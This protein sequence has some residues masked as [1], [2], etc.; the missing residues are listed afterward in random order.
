MVCSI[1]LLL[2][3]LDMLDG[4]YVLYMLDLVDL[5]DLVDLLDLE[6]DSSKKCVPDWLSEYETEFDL[7]RLAP[8]KTIVWL[9]LCILVEFILK[10]LSYFIIILENTLRHNLGRNENVGSCILFDF[11]INSI[12]CSISNLDFFIRF[13]RFLKFS[14]SSL[15]RF[16]NNS[17][18]LLILQLGENCTLDPCIFV[19]NIL[20]K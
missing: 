7:K 20:E 2:D 16:L 5:V 6:I 15:N 10:V 11:L 19:R 8:L 9:K 13:F 12:S 1:C 14:G 17:V 4:L 3:M 18:R